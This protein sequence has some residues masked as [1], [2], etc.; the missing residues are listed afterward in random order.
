MPPP[1]ELETDPTYIFDI[2]AD[3]DCNVNGESKMFLL[4]NKF[5]KF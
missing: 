5:H 4:L 1:P 3:D 2:F